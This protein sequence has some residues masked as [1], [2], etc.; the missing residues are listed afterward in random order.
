M[1]DLANEVW[2]VGPRTN[3]YMAT[4]RTHAE[5]RQ[6]ETIG[7]MQCEAL[8]VGGPHGQVA[9]VPLDESS[10]ERAQ[11]IAAAPKMA[12]MLLSMF[13]H[14]SHGGPTRAEAHELLREAGVL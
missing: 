6:L 5:V 13:S 12:K 1:N 10:K 3:D 4:P 11:L 8:S 14:V 2:E 7:G 9:I